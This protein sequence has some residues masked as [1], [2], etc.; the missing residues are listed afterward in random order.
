MST[1]ARI[2][3]VAGLLIV[4]VASVYFFYGHDSKEADVLVSADPKLVQPPKIPAASDSRPQIN[5]PPAGK[6]L[7][8]APRPGAPA[9]KPVPPSTTPG[10][11][12]LAKP[13]SRS[14]GNPP[15]ANAGP[16]GTP[17][18][19]P[20]RPAPAVTTHGPAGSPAAP[21]PSPTTPAPKPAADHPLGPS[22]P[23]KSDAPTPGS[24][25]VSAAAPS[26]EH[27]SGSSA[28]PGTPTASPAGS[29]GN[30]TTQAT[31]VQLW[32]RPTTSAPSLFADRPTLP[33]RTGPSTELVDATR[34]NLEKSGDSAKKEDLTDKEKEGEDSTETHVAQRPS[35]ERPSSDTVR[36]NMPPAKPA[37]PPAPTETWPKKHAIESGDTLSSIADKY[38]GSSGPDKINALLKANPQIKDPRAMKVG[39]TVTVPEWNKPAG[40]TVAPAAKTAAEPAKPG[41]PV[42]AKPPVPGPGNPPAKTGGAASEAS[43]NPPP[44]SGKTYSVREGETF[45]SIAKAKLGNANRWEELYKLNKDLV[46]G[47]PKRLKPGMTIKLP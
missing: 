8:A 27:K 14:A 19:P 2:G 29:T 35:D 47:D 25:S 16:A 5:P 43:G 46:K 12:P 21:A 34:E 15:L 26:S 40:G 11:P 10:N 37:S 22:T 30:P 39:D 45:Y 32:P 23:A 31:G 20:N 17:G 38:Y 4:V 9:N 33:L 24:G 3:V 1:E 44:D 41:T 6:P 13:P 18:T 36:P 42:A 7:P 28:T